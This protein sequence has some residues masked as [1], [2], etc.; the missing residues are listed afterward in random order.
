M[1]SEKI[2]CLNYDKFTLK[3]QQ[4]NQWLHHYIFSTK[5]ASSVHICTKLTN[6]FLMRTSGL[7]LMYL[8]QGLSK[9]EAP[10]VV[11]LLDKHYEMKIN[12]LALNVILFTCNIVRYSLRR[13]DNWHPVEIKTAASVILN[14]ETLNCFASGWFN[15]C[16]LVGT[17]KMWYGVRIF[18]SPT[19]T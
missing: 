10:A 14:R 2:W 15:F 16:S 8:G 1:I 11:R 5:Q 3:L 12:H 9:T 19:N 17:D 13:I 7:S 18:R 4:G 6:N